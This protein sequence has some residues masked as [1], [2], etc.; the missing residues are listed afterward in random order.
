MDGAFEALVAWE[1]CDAP[2]ILKP[3]TADSSERVG[4]VPTN[5]HGAKADEMWKTAYPGRIAKGPRT[6][7]RTA[8]A[9][10]VRY[11]WDDAALSDE[12]LHAVE[13][14]AKQIPYLG[15]ATSPVV[16]RCAGRRRSPCTRN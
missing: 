14:L 11:A 8:L 13:L 4:F 3:M 9:N 6:W 7:P 5:Q 2:R 16:I 10:S 15:R 1:L 12:H